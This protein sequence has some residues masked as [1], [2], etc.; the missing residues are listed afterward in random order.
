MNNMKAYVL[1]EWEKLE[2]QERPI[3]QLNEGECLIKVKYAGICGSDVHIYGG[4][5]PT[6]KPPVVLCHEF[7]GT[8]E[9]IEGESFNLS[10]GDR[11]V[12]EPLVSCGVCEACRNGNWHVCKTLKLLGIHTDGGFSE[13][14]K[15]DTKKVIK[16]PD[17]LKDEEAA[18][19]EPFAVGFHVN[20][21]A[22]IHTG[23]TVL[24]IGGGPIGVIT[25]MVA[26][27]SGAKEVVF[28]EIND[29]RIEFVKSFGFNT[30]INPIKENA[31]ERVAELTGGE[32]FDVVF[33]VSGSQPGILFAPEACKIRGTI[34]PVGFPSKNPEF[35]IL[36]TIFKEL[37]VVGSRVYSFDHFK[38]AVELLPRIKKEYNIEALITDL[39]PL[40][41]LPDGIKQ[42]KAGEN[43]GKILIKM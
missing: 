1:T 15:V 24:V 38:R 2:L 6:A 35:P 40:A 14:V 27:A 25:G 31:L 5:H 28:S 7:M 3:P 34:V 29:N 13:Y 26:M 41:E 43:M 42:M 18:L 11:V 10:E 33:E 4:H 8:V 37:T 16:V 23:D 19:A 30:I 9:K 36:R 32:G 21:R 12:V 22:G 20:Q 39:K 17:E